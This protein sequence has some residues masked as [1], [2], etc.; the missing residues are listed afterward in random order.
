VL[1]LR[2]EHPEVTPS[3]VALVAVLVVHNLTGTKTSPQLLLS[4]PLMDRPSGV[5]ETIVALLVPVCL[6]TT[7]HEMSSDCTLLCDSGPDLDWS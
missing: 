4:S 6:S 5:F 3:V 2:P 1:P 7:T